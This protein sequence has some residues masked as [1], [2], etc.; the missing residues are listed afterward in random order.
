VNRAVTRCPFARTSYFLHKPQSAASPRRAA[1]YALV[2]AVLALAVFAP[3]DPLAVQ[4][5]THTAL[6]AAVDAPIVRTGTGQL[7]ADI[8]VL[9]YNVKG[10]PWPLRLDL[11]VRDPET[12]MTRIATHL[13]ALRANNR[14]PDIVLIQEG[15][16]DV[17][18]K[19]GALA[20]Y[21][22]A[23]RGPTRA[24]AQTAKITPAAASLA[25]GADW[26]RGE[27]QGPLLDSG[28]HAFSNFPITVRTRRA[29]GRHVCAGFDCLAAKGVLVFTV[30]VPGVPDPVTVLTLHMNANGASGVAEPRALAAHRL[31]MD[32]LAD[33][34]ERATDPSWPLIFGGDF[35]VKAAP[36]RQRYAD[37]RLIGAGLKTVHT[38]CQPPHCSPG[39]PVRRNAH[40]LEPR[41]IQGF[42][43]GARVRVLPLASEEIFAGPENGGQMSDHVGYLVRYR[44]LW[45]AP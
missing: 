9:T 41:D 38:A 34:L 10:L 3:K 21:R 20:H 30:D 27:G 17:A 15:F 2:L 31:Q 29:F 1:T 5:S 39:Y 37:E 45:S 22:Y 24:D 18:A 26:T 35:N 8:S 11:P 44:L 6:P 23:A 32:S 40:W 13:A 16:P 7:A 28:L 43:D 36:A 33:T 14:A 4:A 25:S 12:A 42:R 19:I